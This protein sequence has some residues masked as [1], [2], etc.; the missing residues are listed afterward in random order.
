MPLWQDADLVVLDF[1]VNDGHVPP[2]YRDNDGYSFQ[3]AGG[4]RGF[5]HLMRKS[6]KLSQSPAVALLHFFSWNATRDKPRVR[7]LGCYG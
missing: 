4:R 6:L 7:N 5:E 2:H 1:A 3:T